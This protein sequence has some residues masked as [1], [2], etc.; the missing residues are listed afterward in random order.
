MP[1]IS[2]IV[3]LIVV[4]VILGLVNSMIPMD[5]R[6]KQILNGVVVQNHQAIRGITNHRA[7]GKYVAHGPTG[8]LALQYHNNPVSFRNIWVRPIPLDNEP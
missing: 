2:I 1:F 6:I 8:P 4:G 3:A 5:A 7:V